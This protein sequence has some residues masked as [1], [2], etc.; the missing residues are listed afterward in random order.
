MSIIRPTGNVFN[1]PAGAP[2]LRTFA[3][4]LLDGLIIPGFPSTPTTMSL[5]TATIFVPTRRAARA[6]ANEF[7][8]GSKR[9]ATL[10]PK[11]VPL[12]RVDTIETALFDDDD[13]DSAKMG[14]K[15][16]ISEF[17][18]RMALAKLI[19]G[20]A[21][22][23]R[24]AIVFIDKS[25]QPELHETEPMLVGSSFASAWSM[26][27]DLSRLIDEF[28]IEGISWSALDTLIPEE[29]DQYWGITHRFLKI[30]IDAWPRY[31]GE[32]NLVDRAEHQV[33]LVDREI[34]RIEMGSR[35]GPLIVAGSTGANASTARL[36]A[37][38]AKSSG[39]AIVL[40]GVDQ[41]LDGE[42]WSL[43]AGAAIDGANP[44]ATHPQAAIARLLTSIGISRGDIIELG[45]L[46][47]TARSRS[48]LIS[49]ALR[50]AETT[51]AWHRLRSKAFPDDA[52]SGLEGVSL[53]EAADEREEALSIAIKLRECVELEKRAALV[54]PDRNIA[55]RVKVQLARWNIKVDDSAG[56]SLGRTPYGSYARL[57]L[58]A[59][60]ETRGANI[61]ALLTH[62]RAGFGFEKE[63]LDR[64]ARQLDIA[65]LRAAPDLTQ[66]PD[67][68]IAMA[69][70]LIENNRAH[71]NA[72]FINADDWLLIRR[73]LEK[74]RTAFDGLDHVDQRAAIASWARLHRSAIDLT[75][76]SEGFGDTAGRDILDGLFEELI[77]H[78]NLGE[79]VD[80]RGYSALFDQL[81]AN[82]P[83][84]NQADENSIQIFGLLEARLI[85]FETIVAAGLDEGIWPPKAGSDPFL[86]RA[87][88]ATVNMSPPERRIGQTAHDFVQLLG[89]P[90][91]VI[92]R[93][94]KRDGAPTVPSRFIQRIAAFVGVEP[95][96]NTRDRGSRLIAL[97]RVLDD[98]PRVRIPPPTPR[99][100]VDLRPTSLSVTRIE[101]LRRDPYSIYAERILRLKPLDPLDGEL[102]RREYGVLIHDV[103]S[104]F[105]GTIDYARPQRSTLESLI[106]LGRESFA[107]FFEVPG[108][109]EFSW[110]TLTRIFEAYHAWEMTRASSISSIKL[111]QSGGI[112]LKLNDQSIFNLTARADR[113]ETHVDGS[114][115]VLDFKS[116]R[117]PSSREILV[118]FAPQLVLEAKMI[119]EG[120]FI[121]APA[122]SIG[123][124][125]VK[126]GGPEHLDIKQ[127]GDNKR[128]LQQLM[129]EQYDGLLKLL[130]QLR[131]P[132]TA[133]VSRP[134]PQFINRYG[135]YDHL[136][137]VKE[138]S[139]GTDEDPAA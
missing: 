106:K 47:A 65:V 62:S 34:S 78:G 39:C 74:W 95:W 91:V 80:L 137:R 6:L 32:R 13:F 5:A 133:Y 84:R 66:T 9:K 100:S 42:A 59:A 127:V 112:K 76:P 117:L 130:N 68:L 51:D 63:T 120:A 3:R 29:F 19:S 30:A 27:G 8:Q 93:C 123:A 102:G 57:V 1:I 20:W 41:H 7:V 18:R 132:S 36:L 99:P 56:E 90:E 15:K 89:A 14:Q 21:K 24:R 28:T 139:A 97:S 75:E 88:R 135:M 124:L 126:L 64:I 125:Y 131:Q 44:I 10:L 98:R 17:E 16:Q 73:L 114:A 25:G 12:G 70:L 35:T 108:F 81:C 110:P 82:Q 116:G 85:N 101:T 58:A 118:G 107:P 72:G 111:E 136:A 48:N 129:A 94:L 87:M 128:P 77:E 113:I 45:E 86:N 104:T 4:S 61:V 23:I 40:P 67:E 138:W 60:L 83:V 54:T 50:P 96:R 31:L 55:R 105:S 26:A 33:Q 119:A 79:D 2:F 103:I 134:Y 92:T 122:A 115:W 49:D 37:A 69:R 121:F 52:S 38:I 46:S 11:I 53:I 22:D 71:P 109:R 43:L